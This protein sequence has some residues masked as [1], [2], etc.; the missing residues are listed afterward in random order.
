MT[1]G[2]Q[3]P[4]TAGADDAVSR[5]RSVSSLISGTDEEQVSCATVLGDRI[6]VDLACVDYKIDSRATCLTVGRR[7]AQPAVHGVRRHCTLEQLELV[8]A[9]KDR[10]A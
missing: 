3:C 5:K 6:G 7:G 8:G 9:R 1:I 2:K 10:T 4:T